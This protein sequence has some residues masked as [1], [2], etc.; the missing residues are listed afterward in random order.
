MTNSDIIQLISAIAVSASA[1]V[2]LGV[3]FGTHYWILPLKF[4]TIFSD[5]FTIVV[6][7]DGFIRKIQLPLTFIA[8][9]PHN[10]LVQ[11]VLLTLIDNNTKQEYKMRWRIFVAPD[12]VLSSDKSVIGKIPLSEPSPF[13]IGG[14]SSKQITIEFI[15]SEEINFVKNHN[16]QLILDVWHS[17]KTHKNIL[18]LR[19]KSELVSNSTFL[20]N[21]FTFDQLSKSIE[22]RKN[23]PKKFPPE[24]IACRITEWTE[25]WERNI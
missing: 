16:Y 17:K 25:E 11:K 23:D 1:L 15:S 20:I 8:L 18:K 5:S 24:L 2:A 13:F 19:N 14:R 4:K 10:I 6:S 21:Q 22:P 9:S 3:T 7:Q 12:Y